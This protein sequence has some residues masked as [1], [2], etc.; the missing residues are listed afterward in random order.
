M[1]PERFVAYFKVM[2]TSFYEG[3]KES[4]KTEVKS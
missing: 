3:N 1:S 4:Q 2:F